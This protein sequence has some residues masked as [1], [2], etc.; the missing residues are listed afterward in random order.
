MLKQDTRPIEY[1][2]TMRGDNKSMRTSGKAGV[3]IPVAFVP[4]LRGD[5]AQGSITLNMELAEMPRPLENAVIARGQTWFIPRP[6]LPQ[7]AG[8]DDFTRAWKGVPATRLG[9]GNYSTDLYDVID[10]ADIA[11]AE[12]SEFFTALGI[13]LQSGRAINTDYVDSYIHVQN[14]RL[15]A[16]NGDATRYNYYV[17]NATEALELKPAFWPKGRMSSIVPD[18]EQSLVIG[19]LELDFAAGQLP[20]AGIGTDGAAP[21]VPAG[22]YADADHWSNGVVPSHRS[23]ANVVAAVASDGDVN[24]QIYAEM[25]GQSVTVSLANIDKA[26]TTQAFARRVAAMR[27]SDFS[28]FNDD[29]VL[30]NELMQGFRVPPELFNRPW[31]IDT[32]TVVFGMRERHATDAANLDDSVSVGNASISLSANVPRAEYGG[33]IMATVEV[34]P[35]R[36]YERQRDEYL[37]VT[38]VDD[39]PNAMRDLQ[40]V[41]PVDTVDCGRIDVKHS[42][43]SAV[44]GYEPM[45]SKWRREFTMFGGEFRQLTPGTP[46]E[47][48]RT[49]IWQADYVDPAFTT[50]HFLCPHPFPQN[51]FS[52]PANDCV[53]IG[54]MHQITIM[55]VTQFGDELV[56]NSGDF[57]DVEAQ[58]VSA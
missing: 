22:S 2:Q 27:G 48:A 28:G 19:A 41:E 34:M 57:A 15:A 40:R 23:N 45:N 26:R 43:P 47:G 52:V 21:G 13:A 14:F 16:H 32:K 54:V 33:V 20:V 53:N 3:V 42:T 6:A 55:G 29:D 17:E 5:S 38:G 10:A 56:E 11:T 35:E 18:Y 8:I 7:F 50:D 39:M 36:L 12:A 4:L 37:Y 1:G 51:V 44:Y 46:N 31:A 30:I 9:A 58:Q 49:A 25:A 24:G